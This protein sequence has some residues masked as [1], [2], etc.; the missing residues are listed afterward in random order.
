MQQHQQQQ[1]E[2]PSRGSS[3]LPVN[4]RRHKVAPEQRKRV[5]TAC[6]SCNVRRIKCSG[7]RPCRQCRGSSR[8]CV[9]PAPIEKI[10]VSRNELDDLRRKCDALERA[11]QTKVPD[12]A[13]RQHL[14]AQEGGDPTGSRAGSSSSFTPPQSH[15]LQQQPAQLYRDEAAANDAEAETTGRMLS[16]PDGRSRFLGETS[17]ATFLDYL[18]EFM[19]TV[20]PLAFNKPWLSPSANNGSTFLASLGRYQTY[21]SRPIYEMSNV[22][23]LVLPPRSDMTVMLEDLRYFI[24]D[25][26]GTFPCGGIYWWGDLG[27]VPVD[28]NPAS[29]PPGT[30]R[31]EML[32]KY[33]HLAF[34]HT[35]FAVACQA[36][37][38]PDRM[39]KPEDLSQILFSRA[40]G[41]LGNPL[42]ITSW[43][44]SDVAVLALMGFYLIEMNRRDAAYMYVSN[45]MHIS[46]M[47]GAH[48]G[49][50]DER[51]KRVFWTLYILDRWLSCLMGRPPTIM[52]DAV[53]V[54]LPNDAP[55]LPPAAG[56]RA[57]VQLA[58]ISG[59]IVCN[60]Y[61]VAPY[62][63]QPGGAA[64][65]VERALQML[66]TWLSQLPPTLQM[67]AD[68]RSPDP[69]CCLL[70]MGYNQHLILL[71]RPIFF[72]AVKKAFAERY[73]TTGGRWNIEH[74]AARIRQC[75]DAA[76]RN[77]H[78]AR[79]LLDL[80]KRTRKLLQAGLHYV[81][82]AAIILMLE[83]LLPPPQQ[84]PP[85]SP[86]AES[87]DVNFAIDIFDEET[88]TGSNYARDCATVLKDLRSLIQRLRLAPQG[89]VAASG[90]TVAVAAAARGVVG[91]PGGL[92]PEDV[93]MSNTSSSS[94]PTS[95]GPRDYHLHLDHHQQP[96][97]QQTFPNE[98]DAVYQELMT[99]VDNNEL[100][101]YSNNSY[102]P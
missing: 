22:D 46:M 1:T 87:D 5:A 94:T 11:L 53:R 66:E 16:D 51:G 72:V 30:S 90:G 92:A 78:L 36:N 10:T 44:I 60:T 69:A 96:L 89:V 37:T 85:P 17:G 4:P 59:H 35:A 57:H 23:P 82:N 47:H 86:S 33:R 73:I 52:D 63:H 26:N 61:K 80:T 83:E 27:S 98:G 93:A 97:Q 79:W 84:E 13:E 29:F 14:I 9:Y 25:G 49:W 91:G 7:E 39:P 18:K 95:A 19:S 70:H 6:N 67:P 74:H 76:H 81:F 88:K 3:R 100:Q 77:L 101:V 41:L 45:A 15:T 64:R 50:V 8:D 68:Y 75:S 21:D 34:Y 40:R 12:A 99:W 102:L 38:M 43:T 71:L 56:L 48:R 32:D 42:D 65:H 20:F 24:Q 31:Q 28:P 55:S 58:R 54:P 2:N 62:D